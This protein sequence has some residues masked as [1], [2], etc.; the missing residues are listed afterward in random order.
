MSSSENPG[1]T[2]H[3]T[4]KR[5]QHIDVIID[6]IV[7]DGI[8]VCMGIFAIIGA[9]FIFLSSQNPQ[10]YSILIVFVSVICIIGSIV[11]F[12][13]R[14]NLARQEYFRQWYFYL[15]KDH[16]SNETNENKLLV[17][18]SEDDEWIPENRKTVCLAGK[19]AGGYCVLWMSIFLWIAIVFIVLFLSLIGVLLS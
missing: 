4:V 5:L 10:H 18:P 17:I 2:W 6:Q 19:R 8:I 7:H 14:Q 11:A 13:L 9:V 16:N 3:D 12:H 1:W 15:I